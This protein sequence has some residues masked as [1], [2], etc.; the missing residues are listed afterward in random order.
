M[1]RAKEQIDSYRSRSNGK[2]YCIFFTGLAEIYLKQYHRFDQSQ[3]SS[4]TNHTFWIV[5]AAVERLNSNQKRRRILNKKT[6]FI[7]RP[8]R[9][10]IQQTTNTPT[11]N[12]IWCTRQRVKPTNRHI[13]RKTKKKK[14]VAITYRSG[15]KHLH[16]RMHILHIQLYRCVTDH[17]RLLIASSNRKKNRI[18]LLELA[19][20]CALYIWNAIESAFRGSTDSWATHWIRRTNEWKNKQKI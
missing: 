6:T 1:I 14:T 8:K 13:Q 18:L 11:T 4:Q 15:M 5:S 16:G 12:F 3:K 20:L 2:I 17:W 9:K 10:K 19:F 7:D